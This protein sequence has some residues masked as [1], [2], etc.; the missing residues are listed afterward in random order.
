MRLKKVITFLLF[1]MFPIIVSAKTYD[2]EVI[3]DESEINNSTK[4]NYIIVNH[5]DNGKYYAWVNEL[6]T[7]EN[8]KH[9]QPLNNATIVTF[10]DDF[11]ELTTTENKDILWTFGLSSNSVAVDME[12][13]VLI[14]RNNVYN[15]GVNDTRNQITFNS[16]NTQTSPSGFN[17]SSN[18]YPLDFKFLNDEGN[19]RVSY[20][21]LKN[22]RTYYIRFLS[23]DN[24]FLA[25]DL[26]KSSKEVKI[27]RVKEKYK[28]VEGY[29]IPDKEVI[30]SKDK[31][32][33]STFKDSGIY[34]IDLTL[35]TNKI[36]RN[37]D[38]LMILDISNSMDYEEKMEKLKKSANYLVDTILDINP[39]NRIGIVKFADGNAF[40]SESVALGLSNDLTKIKELIAK[41]STS[42]LGGTNYTDA[43]LLAHE[44]LESNSVKG[45]DQLVIF[46][47]DGAPTI[48]NKTK[49]SVFKNTEDGQVGA[50][51][52]NWTN[53]FLNNELGPVEKMKEAGVEFMTVGVD[54]NKDMA[55]KSDGSFVVKAASAQKLL[56]NIA[57]SEKDFY[58]VND[59][60]DL[61][62]TF[63]KI[64]EILQNRLISDSVTDNIENGYKLLITP[65]ANKIPYIEIKSENG[66]IIEKITFSKDGKKAYSSL[67]PKENIILETEQGM[68]LGASTFNYDF[69][70]KTISWN[71]ENIGED[72]ITFTYFIIPDTE[73]PNTS[74][75]PFIGLITIA[76]I[77]LV[78]VFYVNKKISWLR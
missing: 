78:A 1:L 26:G 53:Y 75:L 11:T 15:D 57:S 17:Y 23:T 46:V 36:K 33:D 68:V 28:K 2:V 44:I 70:A 20:K 60:D 18:A 32:E 52:N 55:I 56:Q 30:F 74:D 73:N 13:V 5:A 64:K 41:D 45:R 61:Q 40:E 62:E 8:S 58:Q 10:N 12:S 72:K 31:I 54:V 3:T 29:V 38:V 71:A 4:D 21:D 22:N 16:T 19:V 50:Y 47:T 43:F 14:G 51:A 59:Y 49:F 65:Y 24:R 27:Y 37:T 34:Q 7:G 35:Q 63:A 66:T 6:M 67:N 69:N 77:S 25:G 76:L 48:Y 42:K 9:T 39:N